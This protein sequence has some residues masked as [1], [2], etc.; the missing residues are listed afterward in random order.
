MVLKYPSGLVSSDSRVGEN[1]YLRARL[2]GSRPFSWVDYGFP[3]VLFRVLISHSSCGVSLVLPL[4][5][6]FKL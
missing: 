4:L 1:H 3:P 5:C 6:Q 2:W